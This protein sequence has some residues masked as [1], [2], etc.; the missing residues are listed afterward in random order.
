MQALRQL[1]SLP[2]RRPTPPWLP[3]LQAVGKGCG[4]WVVPIVGGISALKQERLLAK[5]PEASQ[6]ALCIAA[7]VLR[8]LCSLPACAACAAQLLVLS[9]A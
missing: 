8:V 7:P 4:I 1:V 3:N 6:P 5:H 2:A 9:V